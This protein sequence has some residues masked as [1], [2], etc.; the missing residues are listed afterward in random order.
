[1][2]KAQ[3][4]A[5]SEGYDDPFKMMEECHLDS[6]IMGICMN[7]DCEYTTQVEPDCYDGYCE[8]CETQTVKSLLIL[9][10]VI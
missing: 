7:P 3:Q 9:E 8:E 4:L 10:G 2:S 6:V 1:M 5:E